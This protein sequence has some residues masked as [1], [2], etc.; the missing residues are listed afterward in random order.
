[1]R[2]R[3]LN[4][5]IKSF[6]GRVRIV[7][8][9]LFASFGLSQSIHAQCVGGITVNE[10]ATNAIMSN[11]IQ[12][13]GVTISNFTVTQGV[14]R[15]VS[16]FTNVLGGNNPLSLTQGVLLS[17]GRG[18]TATG[19]NNTS[20][21]STNNNNTF[22]DPDLLLLGPLANRD[23]VIVE[24]DVVPKTDTM[25]L[26]FQWGS[27]EYLEY[28]CSE[29]ND[30]FGFLV[31]GPGITGPYSNNAANF[32]KLPDNTPVSIG[33][34]NQ[35]VAGTFGDPANCASFANTA[36]F[37]NNTGN[38]CL[39][40]DG[41][42]TNLQVKG[43]VTPCGTYHVKCVLADAGDNIYDSWVWLGGFSALGQAVNI[44]STTV[45]Q[46]LVE[47]CNSVQYRARRTG[48]LSVPVVVSLTYSGSS[49]FGVDY[50]GAPT[51][52]SF[53]AGVQDIFFTIT[54]TVDS[55]A[56]GTESINM[57]GAWNICGTPF[58]AVFNLSISDPT[59]T[60]NCPANI[61]INPGCQQVVNF[62]TP[63]ATDACGPCPAPTTLAGYTLLGTTGGHTY[64]KANSTTN[65]AA[66]NTNAIAIGA[67]L[68]TINSATE[69]SWLVANAA[70]AG[71]IGYT[72][73][74]QE[75][76]WV[77]ITGETSTYTNWGVSQPDNSGG[78][79]NWGLLNSIWSDRPITSS[80]WG[81]IEFECAMSQTGGPASGSVFP[82][83][84]TPVT[85]QATN[86]YSTTNCTF[87]V[88]IVDT[89]NPTIS[90][91][92]NTTGTT[93][94]GT[95]AGTVT[96]VNP[97]TNDNCGV[98]R[99]TW[100]LTGATIATSPAT[101]INF[102]GTRSFNGGV[103]TVTY[104]VGDAGGNIWPGLAHCSG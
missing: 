68:V 29:F 36:F 42:T 72:D 9:V 61:T 17:T 92:A 74:S 96:T 6:I 54:P 52:L 18:N 32:A 28:T 62:L 86:G 63:T 20:S 93:A 7:T 80:S 22:N 90:C 48:D 66:A 87:N 34:V 25:Q 99:L 79:E 64:F 24:F 88:T 104:T 71:W 5:T 73:Q 13:T 97:T 51:T 38:L 91:P 69:Q 50:T 98:T 44:T 58:T 95:C 101:G 76:T 84:T 60:I 45:G 78:A 100:A 55:L 37:I 53:G 41:I 12:G 21:A 35:G 82:V 65:W 39:Q 102:V 77:W 81:I 1:M 70:G 26:I 15:Q 3:M 85:F 4:S 27:E 30:V 16:S 103:T 56:E 83:G 2:K 43:T 40:A 31:S 8:A 67:H 75:G 49:S 19:P 59:V 47:G 57:N 46:S 10:T 11:L 33:T 14:D 89:T 94:A 23:V